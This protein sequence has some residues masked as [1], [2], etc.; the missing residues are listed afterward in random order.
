MGTF[1]YSPNNQ[2]TDLFIVPSNVNTI[3]ISCFRNIGDLGVFEDPDP[4]AVNKWKTINQVPLQVTPGKTWF[5]N[6]T[7]VKQPFLNRPVYLR[8]K[9]SNY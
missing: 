3:T 5:N 1:T 6:N 7:I 9:I 2:N 8:L 4:L